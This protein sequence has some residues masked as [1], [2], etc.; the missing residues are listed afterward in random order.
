MS[1]SKKF[2]CDWFY[3]S[4]FGVELFLIES[5]KLNE[6]A[7]PSH[8]NMI[9]WFSPS[10]NCFFLS[11]YPLN[12]FHLHPNPQRS[13]RNFIFFIPCF[14]PGFVLWRK[15]NRDRIMLHLRVTINFF[16]FG[17][18]TQTTY[19]IVFLHGSKR[20]FSGINSFNWTVLESFQF[21]KLNDQ[22]L[23]AEVLRDSKCLAR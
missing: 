19:L 15:I 4:T 1:W 13:E 22:Q 18:F 17:F 23:G 9:F 7:L 14:S 2:D 10:C 11:H 16:N 6:S 5:Q 21:E 8:M 12:C 20:R 3:T